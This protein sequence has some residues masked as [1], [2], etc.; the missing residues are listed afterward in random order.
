MREMYG[1]AAILLMMLPATLFRAGLQG[2]ISPYTGFKEPSQ[3]VS[4]CFPSTFGLG[5]DGE[6]Q[7]RPR[8]VL[9]WW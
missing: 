3:R 8:R 9:V 5:K 7:L 2:T 4:H 6:K 1:Y